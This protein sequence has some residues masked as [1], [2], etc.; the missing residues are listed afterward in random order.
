MLSVNLSS[1]T[2]NLKLFPH[3]QQEGKE[4]KLPYLT[5]WE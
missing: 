4:V 2:S 3:A 1:S 5:L